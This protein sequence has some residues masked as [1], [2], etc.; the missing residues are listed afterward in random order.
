MSG[1]VL[2]LREI[3]RT[4]T[5]LA[6]GKGAGLGELTRIGGIRVPAGFCVTTAAFHRVIAA[7]PAFR[8]A[9]DRLSLLN[10]DDHTAIRMRRE[11]VRRTRS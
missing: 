1:Y 3:D 4:Q 10:A 11:G 8:K 9:V 6:G 2:D 5:G 7:A